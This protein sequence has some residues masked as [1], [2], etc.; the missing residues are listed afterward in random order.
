MEDHKT[1]KGQIIVLESH[2]NC[3]SRTRSPEISN[4]RENYGFNS[5]EPVTLGGKHEK[6]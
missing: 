1:V 6:L 2:Q 5:D 3:L 4:K